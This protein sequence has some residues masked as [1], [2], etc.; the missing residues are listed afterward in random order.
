MAA[1]KGDLLTNAAQ[2][3]LDHVFY[4]IAFTATAS[5]KILHGSVKTGE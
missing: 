2:A 3:L 4:R 1:Y 5:E